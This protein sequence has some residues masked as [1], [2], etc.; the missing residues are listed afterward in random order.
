MSYAQ[1]ETTTLITTGMLPMLLLASAALTAPATLFLLWLYR[2]A[3]ERSMAGR[4]GYAAPP[5]TEG[6]RDVGEGAPLELR[7]IEATEVG[8]LPPPPLYRTSISSLFSPQ[9]V[10]VTA[11]LTYAL[12]LTCSWLVFRSV[13]GLALS[14]FL[15]LMSCYGW[16]TALAVGM[17]AAVS[18]GQRALVALAYFGMLFAVAI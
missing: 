4:V 5:F 10:Y 13:D 12:V 8:G 18:R 17:L 2:R 11:G 3:V 9:V 1:S 14:R 15:W 7:L 16:P 6:A